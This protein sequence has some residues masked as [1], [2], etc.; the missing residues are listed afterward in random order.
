VV[1]NLKRNSVIIYFFIYRVFV[2]FFDTV[3]HSGSC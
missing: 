2:F 1:N 3:K